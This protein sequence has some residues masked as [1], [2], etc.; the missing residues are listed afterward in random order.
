LFKDQL[1]AVLILSGF[2]G[3]I[4]SISIWFFG[5]V[6]PSAEEPVASWAVQTRAAAQGDVYKVGPEVTDQERLFYWVLDAFG[7]CALVGIGILSFEKLFG[8][9]GHDL[10]QEGHWSKAI[11][12][13]HPRYRLRL[14]E[15]S[16]HTARRSSQLRH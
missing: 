11:S 9:F 8:C 3:I 4:I 10:D 16:H 6:V 15:K 2:A 13:R 14:I 5:S 1:A 7:V 12:E